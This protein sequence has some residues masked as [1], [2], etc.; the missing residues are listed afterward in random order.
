[1]SDI[2]EADS[3]CMPSQ[4]VNPNNSVQVVVPIY[5]VR[6]EQILAH[7]WLA[8]DKLVLKV[9]WCGFDITEYHIIEDLSNCLGKDKVANYFRRISARSRTT[10]LNR[11]PWIANAFFR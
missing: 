1:M 9:S 5:R 4:D 10:I 7:K 6:I 11:K 8:R 2:V 3:T